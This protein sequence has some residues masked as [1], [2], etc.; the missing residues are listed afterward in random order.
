MAE[1]KVGVRELKAKLSGYLQEMKK[2][3][4][5][6]IT[7][8]GRPVGRIVPTLESLEDRVQSLVRSGV[9]SWSGHTL[10]PGRPLG[11]LKSGSKT[12]AE[13]VVEDR[14]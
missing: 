7:D 11:K 12:L 14:D 5:I 4:T 2:G 10:K 6:V 3:H 9:A 8:R 1:R 13:I